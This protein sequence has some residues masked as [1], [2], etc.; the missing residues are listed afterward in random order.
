MR[1]HVD[2]KN[3]ILWIGVTRE[4]CREMTG[5]DDLPS[6]AQHIGQLGFQAL[7]GVRRVLSLFSTG[8]GVPS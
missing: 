4:E 8:G 2:E 1:V 6:V 7:A 3:G 5:V